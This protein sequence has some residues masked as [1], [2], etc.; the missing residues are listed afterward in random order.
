MTTDE[1]REAEPHEPETPPAAGTVAEPPPPVVGWA[2]P[3][4]AVAP[5]AG[6]GVAPVAWATP[7]A[8]PV[9]SRTRGRIVMVLLPV[10]S[11]L[12]LLIL[13][14][15]MGLPSLL[16]DFDRGLAS[17]ATLESWDAIFGT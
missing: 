13:L 12:S 7:G 16:E 1:S 17:R 4:E 10:Y 14:H 5:P 9:P 2:P 11:V 15:L 8:G 6:A 3:A